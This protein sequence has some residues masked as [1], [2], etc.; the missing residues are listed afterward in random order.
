M[1]KKK[2][3][4]NRD[5]CL[6]VFVIPSP[7]LLQSQLLISSEALAGVQEGLQRPAL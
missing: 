1:G 2:K 6:E 5:A 7:K 4:K 3:K